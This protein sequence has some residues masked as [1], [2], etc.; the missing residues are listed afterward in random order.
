MKWI[1]V[2]QLRSVVSNRK[3]LESKLQ[4]LISEVDRKPKKHS[5]KIYNRERI[6]TDICIVLFH[7]REKVEIG[8]S[9]L[10]LCLVAALKEFGLVNHSIWI[11]RK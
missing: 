9:R 10:S 6:D 2:I 3:R 5:I 8:G 4:K 11:E 1:E 7:D